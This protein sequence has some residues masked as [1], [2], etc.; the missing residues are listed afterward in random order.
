M[1]AIFITSGIWSAGMTTRDSASLNSPMGVPS[2]AYTVLTRESAC[3]LS[4]GSEAGS[5]IM[6]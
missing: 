1:T 6:R 4:W 5:G 2:T 3:G